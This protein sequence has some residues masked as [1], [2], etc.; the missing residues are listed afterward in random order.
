MGQEDAMSVPPDRVVVPSSEVGIVRRRV[1]SADGT[2]LT[3]TRVN[4]GPRDLLLVP[5]GPSPGARWAAV[6]ARLDGSFSCWLM[7]RRGKGDSGDREP[8]GFAREHEDLAAVLSSF[9]GAAVGVAAHSSGATVALGAAAR[10]VQ[11]AWLALYEPPWPVDGPLGSREIID[12]IEASIAAGDRDAALEMAFRDMVGM[13]ATAVA[14][15]MG[16][17][18]WA[19]WRS[20][21]HTWPREMRE[22]L[23]MPAGVDGLAAVTTPTLLL[24]GTLSPAHLRRACEAIVTALAAATLVDLPGQG[25]GA[26]DTG[27]DLVA[28][29]IRDFAAQRF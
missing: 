16:S 21:A 9:H 28:S 6:A 11:P 3:L 10:G 27:P 2:E 17:P 13:P 7:D 5:G 4:E 12:A 20:L 14:A 24:C 19:E 23:A 29:A 18:V 26:L 25:H 1:V 8:Y 15:L 22:L